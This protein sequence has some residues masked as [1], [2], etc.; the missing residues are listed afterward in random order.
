MKIDLKNKCS[1][2]GNNVKLLAHLGKY[3]R[4][5]DQLTNR[6]TDRRL[7]GSFTSN[8]RDGNK[9]KNISRSV[10]IVKNRNKDRSTDLKKE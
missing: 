5:T 6:P 2:R 8:N 7:L 1:D 4:Q 10:A 3:D 9:S